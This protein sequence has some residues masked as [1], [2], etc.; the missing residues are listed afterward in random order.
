[1]IQGNEQE[2]TIPLL[3]KLVE[4]F[5]HFNVIRY[6]KLWKQFEQIGVSLPRLHWQYLS[7]ALSK[8]ILVPI[9]WYWAIWDEKTD[10]CCTYLLYHRE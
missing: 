10:N 9:E 6:C 2:F 7:I 8:E 5:E 3:P 4:L 1:M